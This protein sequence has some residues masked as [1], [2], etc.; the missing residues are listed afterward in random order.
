MEYLYVSRDKRSGFLRTW[1]TVETSNEYFERKYQEMNLLNT[2]LRKPLSLRLPQSVAEV[3]ERK[4]QLTALIRAEHE[5]KDWTSTETAWADPGG[6]IGPFKFKY[7]YQRADLEVEGCSFYELGDEFGYETVYTGSGMGAI[8][9]VILASAHVFG[10]GEVIVPLGAYG[11]T[12]E[13]IGAYAHKLRTIL[14]KDLPSEV[15]QGTSPKLLLL[16]SC[17]PGGASEDVLRRVGKSIELIIFDTTCF[18]SESGRIRRVLR[19]AQQ[20][21]VPVIMVRSHNKLDSLGTEY[22]R[23]GSASFVHSADG[24]APRGRFT[25]TEFLSETKNAVR[26][27]G[28]AALPAHFPPYIGAESYRSLTTRR[29]A[30]ILRN[31]RRAT[32]YFRS[33]LKG[34]ASEL[35]F[36]H[37]LY[38]TL[39][40]RW[41]LD[42][43]S[44]KQAA[45]Q[46]SEDLNQAGLPIRHAG[47]FGF[48]FAATEW[49]H[50]ETTDQYSVRIA[51]ADLPSA[52]WD[53][54]A[55]A[56]AKWWLAKQHQCDE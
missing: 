53:E 28:G 45:A 18:A 44:A 16:D 54:L 6:G 1:N 36:A 40:G 2:C 42:E 39:R 41:P 26:L 20:L 35:H 34:L 25:I 19:W 10:Q 27:L 31:G 21:D 38:V 47:S 17:A 12:I 15:R 4:F 9:A 13:L 24:K 43:G 8:S 50:D 5:L 33:V 30:A 48:D 32:R 29:V 3:V 23:L 11:E 7:D 46:M 37:G 55:E 52:L 14:L 51:V 22:G 49:F 56:I